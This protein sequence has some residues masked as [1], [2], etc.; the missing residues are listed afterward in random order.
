MYSKSIIDRIQIKSQSESDLVISGYASV[1]N[2]VDQHNEIIVKGSFFN[3]HYSK[4]KLL[5]QHDF[6]KPIGVISALFEDEYG[7]KIEGV[8][9]GKIKQGAE[10]IELLKQ[11]AISGLSIGFYIKSEEYNKQGQKVISSIDLKEVSIVTFPAN[12]SAQISQITK[13][14]NQHEENMEQENINHKYADKMNALELKVDSMH[15]MLSRPEITITSDNEQQK[16]FQNYIRAGIE[17]NFLL[18]S[19]LS[20]DVNAGGALI[21]RSLYHKIITDMQTHS[22]MR[23]LASIETIS[24][25]SLDIIRQDEN[26]GNGWIGEVEARADTNSSKLV[27][28]RIHVHELYA[29]PKATQRLIDDSELDI[30][31]WL[32]E[33][34]RDSFVVSENEAF[35]NGD[36]DKK[37]IGLLHSIFNKHR[38]CVV[39]LKSR[40]FSSDSLLEM[41]NALDERYLPNATFLMNRSTLSLIQGFKDATGR[42]IWQASMS[43][44]FKQ[45]IFGIPVVCCANF[46]PLAASK[47]PVIVLGDIKSAYKIVD[48]SG[49][50]IMRDPYTDKPFVKFYAVKRVGGDLMNPKALRACIVDVA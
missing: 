41:I 45:S 14:H 22:P 20:S 28:H 42:F 46:P 30:Q 34:L 49:I 32:I 8:I 43:D 13:I 48:R 40:P 18:K 50:N 27:P 38:D 21:E 12:E 7:L 1:F 16:A 6:A 37:P 35:I 24:T 47:E 26:F 4:V 29:Q 3:S 39:N 2:V 17:N 9:N 44:S 19:S 10:A 5:W 36:G 25:N 33:R 31:N 23:Q 11:G 15:K